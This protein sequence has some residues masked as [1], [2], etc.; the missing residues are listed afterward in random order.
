MAA[1]E[2]GHSEDLSRFCDEVLKKD[3]RNR[4][5]LGQWVFNEKRKEKNQW[6]RDEIKAKLEVLIE[7][8]ALR[9]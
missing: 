5:A 3:P 2:K 6:N 9:K 7:C 1:L 4:F 8:D